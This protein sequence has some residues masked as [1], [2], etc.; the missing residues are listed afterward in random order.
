VNATAKTTWILRAKLA[1]RYAE[2][3][4][5]AAPDGGAPG[6]PAAGVTLIGVCSGGLFGRFDAMVNLLLCVLV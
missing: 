2:R 5:P 3:Y 1:L 6:A 4:R